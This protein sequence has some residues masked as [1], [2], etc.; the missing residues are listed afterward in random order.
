MKIDFKM[1]VSMLFGAGLV[2]G[3]Q[4][5]QT[6]NALKAEIIPAAYAGTVGNVAMVEKAELN[7]CEIFFSDDRDVFEIEINKRI[8]G[9]KFIQSN[10]VWSETTKNLGFYA[11]ICY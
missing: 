2:W 7:N 10:I 3:I 6:N 11:L 1:I 4:A 9:T 8:E 5:L